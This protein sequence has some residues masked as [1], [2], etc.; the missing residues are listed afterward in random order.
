MLSG[1]TL[2]YKLDFSTWPNKLDPKTD[3]CLAF[4][5]DGNWVCEANEYVTTS[6]GFMA[7][8]VTRIG[9]I[10]SLIVSPNDSRLPFGLSRFY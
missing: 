9:G 8:N 5:V 3:V 7:F 10:Y 6:D 4:E 2:E 1:V